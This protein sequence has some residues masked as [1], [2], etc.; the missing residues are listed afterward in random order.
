MPQL[1]AWQ[2]QA[3]LPLPRHRVLSTSGCPALLLRLR[4]LLL[5]PGQKSKGEATLHLS[6]ALQVFS[7]VRVQNAQQ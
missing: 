2:R 5:L 1:A 6:D 3:L 4:A 7:L